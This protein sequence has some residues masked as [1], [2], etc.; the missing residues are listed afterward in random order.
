MNSDKNN[1]NTELYYKIKGFANYLGIIMKSIEINQYNNLLLVKIESHINNFYK[2]IREENIKLIPNDQNTLENDQNTLDELIFKTKGI[3]YKIIGEI[4]FFS[5]N[6]IWSKVQDNDNLNLEKIMNS[7]GIIEYKISK[8]GIQSINSK[9]ENEDDETIFLFSENDTAESYD[10]ESPMHTQLQLFSRSKT[11]VIDTNSNC[12]NEKSDNESDNDSDNDSANQSDNDSDNDSANQSDNDSTNQSDNDSDND[13]ANQSDTD[14]DSDSD[15]EKIMLQHF[16]NNSSN[17]QKPKKIDI[18]ED[19]YLKNQ[20]V[21][22]NYKNKLPKRLERY[23]IK[24][25]KNWLYQKT[26]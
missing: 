18:D 12:F 4:L 19:I 1:M 26:M 20:H 21:L 13:S 14:K 6:G 11:N 3:S 10:D 9:E 7:L 22:Y 25:H 24:L 23:R 15:V 8:D 2:V 5:N 17:K 16:L